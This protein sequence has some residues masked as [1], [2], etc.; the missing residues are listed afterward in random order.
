MT[1]KQYKE[2]LKSEHWQKFRQR[3]YQKRN[4]CAYCSTTENLNI[5]HITYRRL[6]HEQKKDI[7]VLCQEHHFML[8]DG[9]LVIIPRTRTIITK[10]KADLKRLG[11]IAY[12]HKERQTAI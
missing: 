9:L 5:H 4:H 1:K 8:H 10:E 6:N 7:V 12:F 3:T 11:T 2:Y